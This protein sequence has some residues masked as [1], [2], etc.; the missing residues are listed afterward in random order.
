[1][2]EL[3]EEFERLKP[4]LKRQFLQPNA[5][6]GYARCMLMLMPHVI[7]WLEREKKAETRPEH[8]VDGFANALPNILLHV[9]RAYVQAGSQAHALEVLL[10]HVEQGLRPLLDKTPKGIIVPDGVSMQ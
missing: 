7:E 4:H 3:R 8:V 2:N 6:G 5:D 10:R 1:M 9:L